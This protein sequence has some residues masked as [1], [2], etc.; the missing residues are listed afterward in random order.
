MFD[1]DISLTALSCRWETNVRD[2][3]AIGAMSRNSR[4]RCA[5]ILLNT[6]TSAVDRTVLTQAIEQLRLLLRQALL[7]REE[8]GAGSLSVASLRG[9]N[10]RFEAFVYEPRGFQGERAWRDALDAVS[11]ERG[12]AFALTQLTRN[13]ETGSLELGSVRWQVFAGSLG[14]LGFYKTCAP[15]MGPVWAMAVL[16]MVA[17]AAVLIDLGVANPPQADEFPHVKAVDAEPQGTWTTIYIADRRGRVID[18]S[19]V[20]VSPRGSRPPH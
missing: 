17:A 13:L 15:L 19:R 2:P 18:Q 9:L 3:L 20:W 8:T 4:R 5:Q 16:L 7:E 11:G 14:A 10:D 6:D 1:A 12:L